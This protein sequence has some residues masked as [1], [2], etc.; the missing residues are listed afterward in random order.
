MATNHTT[1]YQLNLWEPG[2]SF[3]REEFNQNSRKLD[4]ALGQKADQSALDLLSNSLSALTDQLTELRGQTEA[5]EAKLPRVLLR[6]WTPE[7]PQGPRFS[8]DLTGLELDSYRSLL[9]QL[10]FLS[11]YD[12]AEV[13]Y[14]L[15][16][17]PETSSDYYTGSSS[18]GGWSLGSFR[19]QTAGTPPARWELFPYAQGI[20]SRFYQVT[21]EEVRAARF[22][23]ENVLRKLTFYLKYSPDAKIQPGS[24]ISIWGVR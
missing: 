21:S 12:N 13:N 7:T 15:N 24:Q 9:V 3:L 23:G 1:N 20:I 19:C 16:D 14:L 2:D 11:S 17:P 22:Q 18:T 5:T 4:A 8:V 6:T 10:D